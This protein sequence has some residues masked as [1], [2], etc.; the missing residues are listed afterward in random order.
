MSNKPKKIPGKS[1]ASRKPRYTDPADGTHL[2]LRQRIALAEEIITLAEKLVRQKRYQPFV[3][4]FDSLRAYEAWRK[5]QSN[6][7]L[8]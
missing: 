7:W 6:P 8:V 1:K 3:K 2:S 5:K 4:S